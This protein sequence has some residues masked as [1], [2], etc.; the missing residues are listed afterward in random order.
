MDQ[1]KRLNNTSRT[2]RGAETLTSRMELDKLHVL[3]GQ[4][5]PS[6]HRSAVSCAR[7]RR[8]AREIATSEPTTNAHASNPSAA[9]SSPHSASQSAVLQQH[10]YSGVWLHMVQLLPSTDFQ[11]PLVQFMHI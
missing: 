11:G 1:S 4:T 3:V 6:H 10:L 7:V 8:S 2:W 9:F 5:A